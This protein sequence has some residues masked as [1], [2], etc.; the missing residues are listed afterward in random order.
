MPPS[1]SDE[2]QGGFMKS[3]LSRIS[4]AGKNNSHV[5]DY[6]TTIGAL[7][8]TMTK[9]PKQVN[10]NYLSRP[11]SVMDSTSSRIEMPYP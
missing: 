2:S 1:P 11:S 5:S 4:G 8:I 6:D 10:H 9:K 3:R 7:E